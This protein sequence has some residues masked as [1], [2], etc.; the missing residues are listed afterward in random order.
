MAPRIKYT[1]EIIEFIKENFNKGYDWILTEL[2]NKYN[3]KGDKHYLRHICYKNNLRVR[4]QQIYTPEIMEFI[5]SYTPEHGPKYI[6]EQLK[7]HFDIDTTYRRFISACSRNKICLVQKN[8]WTPEIVEFIRDNSNKGMVWLIDNLKIKFNM[9]TSEKSIHNICSKYQIKLPKYHRHLTQYVR[10]FII[11]HY[12]TCSYEEL[13]NM[14]NEKF[15]IN[16]DKNKVRVLCNK[17]LNLKGYDKQTYLNKKKP[18][19][20]TERI[21]NSNGFARVYIRYRD[22]PITKETGR[23]HDVNWMMKTRYVWEQHNG[24][25]PKGHCIVQLDGDTLNCNIENLRCVSTSIAAKLMHYYGMG[26]V[27]DAM[28]EILKLE[29]DIKS[30]SN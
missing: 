16:T 22:I 24:P 17:F 29:E 2:L 3:I 30:S 12:N 20:G 6:F 11:E 28:I 18:P 7:L 19:I 10:D 23:E 13:A 4:K 5:K 21:I 27:T 25:I 9:I 1:P 14:V 15:N 8:K 26:I